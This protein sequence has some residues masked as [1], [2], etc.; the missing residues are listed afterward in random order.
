MRVRLFGR[1]AWAA[2]PLAVLALL[3]GAGAAA[4]E[5]APESAPIEDVGTVPVE[6]AAPEAPPAD[7]G[8]DATALESIEVTG[9]RIKRSDYET[10]SPVLVI[11]RE[12]LERT[13]LVSIG[14]IL[15]NLPQS[16]AALSRAFNNGG[17]GATE[18]DL[19]NLGSQRVLVL[20][21]GRRW[22]GGVS[23]FNTSGVDLNTIPI[24]VI[25]S[26]EILKDGASAIYGSDAITGVVNIKTR[27]DYV[28]AEV[29]GHVEATDQ[30]D[31]VS[32]LL[33]F[34]AGTVAGK[35]SIFFDVSHVN[36]GPLY[37]GDREQSSIPKF[38]MPPENTS[39]GS[40]FME[41]GNTIFIPTPQNAQAI[42]AAGGAPQG[43]VTSPC[44]DVTLGLGLTED[45]APGVVPVIPLPVGSVVTLCDLTLDHDEFA[46]GTRTFKR[47]DMNTDAY[48]YAPVNYLITPSERTSIYGQ[49]SHQL[50]DNVRLS[51]EVL[52]NARQSKQQLAETPDGLGDLLGAKPFDIGYVA[53]DN[54]YNPTNPASPYYIPGTEPQDIGKGDP[55]GGLVGLGAVLRRFRELGPRLFTQNVDTMRIGGG[56]DGNFDFI[57]RLFSWDT[58]FAFSDNK[59]SASDAGL[60]NNDR[61]ARASGPLANCVGVQ[62]P[63]DPNAPVQSPPPAALGCVPFDWF[64]GPGSLTPEMLNY[65]QY[66]AVDLARQRQRIY[67]GNLSS[68][69]GE[70]AR[71]L[72][73]P[74]GIA[75]GVEYREEF[76]QAQPDP[77]KV[78]QTSST[79][80]VGPTVGSYDVQEGYLELRAP[81]LADKPFVRE[82]ELSVAGRYS[83][84]SSFGDNLSGKFGV[85]YKPLDELILRSTYSTAFRAPAV[86]DLYLGQAVSFPTVTDPC[87]APSTPNEQ[88]NCDADGATGAGTATSQL[89][90]VFGGNPDLDPETAKTISAGFVY[91]PKFLPDFNVYLDWYRITL[92]DFIG[93]LDANSTLALCYASD[94]ANRAYCDAVHRNASGAL[95]RVDTI[96]QNFA[97]VE[98]EG[99]DFNFDW[100]LPLPETFRQLGTFKWLLDASYTAR[101]DQT[102]PTANGEETVG[103]AGV[104]FG[105]SGAIPRWKINTGATW[106]RGNWD[107]AWNV[108][109]I[110]HLWESCDDGLQDPGAKGNVLENPTPV[111][112]LE[113][114]GLCSDTNNPSLLFGGDG[115]GGGKANELKATFYNDVQASYSLPTW[116]SKVT[117]GVNNLL[118]QDPPAARS[119]FA[120]S[121][122]KVTHDPW[123]SRTPYLRLQVNF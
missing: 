122:D 2:R 7:N 45:D 5:S 76:F 99:V 29:R 105:G 107:A 103:L 93:G 53:S 88:T 100:I 40:R 69:I 92:D 112:S 68:E 30:G 121:Y 123:S 61:L 81:L 49:L 85:R 6:P 55:G 98:V 12:D 115:T 91:S 59:L 32:H 96:F 37:S 62:D 119:A 108:R 1:P 110:S 64:G 38:G 3:L 82:L 21:N 116:N 27:R 10:E 78:E 72:A 97:T 80:S 9:S 33:S 17:N 44:P 22:V 63:T 8:D 90:V 117:L 71:F 39:R 36:Q 89:P 35:T 57:A 43:G 79:N 87:E 13:G 28:G 106:N 118:D 52:Y 18:I 111:L 50:F 67:Y 70:L 86:T 113:E 31:G 23:A 11:R 94:P 19:R 109:Y 104:E 65:I 56:A 20:V 14:D 47:V 41:Y 42:N 58:G 95:T 51:S 83:K 34:S 15:Q 101:Y 114:Y 26:I 24:S 73:G 46:N 74:L 60:I 48:N 84:Y 77:L 102:I 120:D 54:P 16:G 25:D 4:Q 75:A 66:T